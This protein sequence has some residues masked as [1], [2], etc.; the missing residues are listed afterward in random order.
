MAISMMT[1]YVVNGWVERYDRRDG[2]RYYTCLECGAME[3]HEHG[4]SCSHWCP[5]EEECDDL[6]R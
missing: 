1:Q 2:G 6:S 5:L 3:G 4:K